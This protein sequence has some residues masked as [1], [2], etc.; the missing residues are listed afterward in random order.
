MCAFL[1]NYKFTIKTVFFFFSQNDNNKFIF[2]PFKV[3]YYRKY[4]I[5]P[6]KLNSGYIYVAKTTKGLLKRPRD[7]L[8]QSA[9]YFCIY[10][11]DRSP[12]RSHV[13]RIIN[14]TQNAFDFAP[15]AVAKTLC[16]SYVAH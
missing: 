7:D 4:A 3:T 10:F 6:F 14:F 5:Y 13:K 15:F 9:T 8:E 2:Q 11:W 1:C 16:R 12:F